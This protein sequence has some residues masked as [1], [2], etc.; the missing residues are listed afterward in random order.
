MKKIESVLRS[1]MAQERMYNLA[2]LNTEQ[3]IVNKMD[4]IDIID[5]LIAAKT[6]KSLDCFKSFVLSTC[7]FGFRSHLFLYQKFF[8]CQFKLKKYSFSNFCDFYIFK[9]HI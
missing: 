6:M 9:G 8:C 2:L 1:S 7:N 4:F 5:L 3:D